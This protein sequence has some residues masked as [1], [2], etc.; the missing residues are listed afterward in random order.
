MSLEATRTLRFAA[1]GRT[2]T[3]PDY[4]DDYRDT[5]NDLVPRTT[6]LP[7][8]D[9]GY[10]E[11]GEEPAPKAIGQVS[12]S[13]T[14]VANSRSQMTAKRDAVKAMDQWGVGRLYVQPSD[15]NL[16]E[17]F[18]FARVNNINM[19]EKRDRHTDLHQPVTINYQV[20]D[21]Y[22]YELGTEAWSWGDGTTWGSRKWGGGAPSYACN[23]FETP[24]TLSVGG[25][26]ITLPRISLSVGA[27]K[28]VT[29]PRIERLENGV[30]R[31]YV[32]YPGTLFGGDTLEINARASTVLLNDVAAYTSAFSYFDV[33]W[34]RLKPGDNDIRVKFG[35]ATDEGTMIFRWY[36]LWS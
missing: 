5:F 28:S 26:A 33:D 25:N 10:D 3:F 17:R 13:F 9:G 27:G 2:Y 15:P 14:L 6:R 23:G 31:D 11:Y 32:Q 36:T 4:Q 24:V 34:F 12:V 21:P 30:V 19:P 18:A 29:N 1:S 7:G 35:S 22:W 20:S 16:N 8:A